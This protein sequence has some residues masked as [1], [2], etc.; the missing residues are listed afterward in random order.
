VIAGI[1]DRG[2][3]PPKG[4]RD[5]EGGPTNASPRRWSGAAAQGNARRLRIEM[6]D[7]ERALWAKL[8][9]KQLDGRRF[10]RQVPLGPY[11]ADF[12]CMEPKLVVELD[13]HQHGARID[14]DARR[15]EWLEGQGF[16]VLRFGNPDVRENLEGVLLTIA[17]VLREFDDGE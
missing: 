2:S 15:T 8:R 5:R 9:R 1:D 4:G 7:A 17:N 13:G 6:T 10:R 3:P 16:H 12:A 14:H 11:V